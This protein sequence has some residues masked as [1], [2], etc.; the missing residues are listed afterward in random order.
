MSIDRGM[1]K[2]VIYIYI[3]VYIYIHIYTHTHIDTYNGILLSHKKEGHLAICKSMD[4]PRGH[5][6]K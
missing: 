5:Y 3:Y 6:A 2:D 4:G 1:D